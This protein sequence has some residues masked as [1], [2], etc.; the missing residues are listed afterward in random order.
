MKDVTL[1]GTPA[2]YGLGGGA[3]IA[4][5][6]DKS[7]GAAL[8]A[9]Y[10]DSSWTF[11]S[12]ALAGRGTFNLGTVAKFTPYVTAGPGWNIRGPSQ[13]VV[14]VAGGGGSLSF[15]KLPKLAFFG[16]FV[17]ILNDTS[18]QRVQAGITYRF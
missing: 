3:R 7:I 8:D 14:A 9:S 15:T 16:E 18:V 11:A 17:T 12:L 1:G 4:Y 13:S 10:C 2:A 6:V 5:W